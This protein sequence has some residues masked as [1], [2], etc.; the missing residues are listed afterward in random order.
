V[1]VSLLRREVSTAKP[2]DPRQ[3]LFPGSLA[4]YE[5]MTRHRVWQWGRGSS[6]T[7]TAQYFLLEM[8]LGTPDVACI[9][10]V[11]TAV[12]A[13]AVA[14]P[15]FVRWNREYKLGG[16]V[17]GSDLTITFPNGSRVFVTGADRMDLFDR[18]KGIKRIL[19]VVL[20]EAQD[21]LTSVLDYAVTKVFAP[22]LGDLEAKYGLKGRIIIEGTGT[23]KRGYFYRAATDDPALGPSLEFGNAHKLTQWHNPHIADP[24]GEFVAACKLGGVH[25]RKLETPVV[26]PGARPRHYDTD[27]ELTR[28]EW[29]GENNDGAS[30]LQIFKVPQT[31]LVK[32]AMVPTKDLEV[33]CS[34]DLGTVDACAVVTYVWTLHDPNIYLVE[35]VQQ[36]GLAGD[37]QVR[38]A[39]EVAKRQARTYGL[40]L[41]DVTIVGDGAGQGKALLM[42]AKK[43][44][45]FEDLESAEK[46]DKVPNVRLMAG[47]LKAETGTLKICDDEKE[48]LDELKSPEWHPDFV[49][50]RIRGHV[51]DRVDAAYQGFRRA[52]ELHVYEPAPPEKTKLQLVEEKIQ[53]GLKAARTRKA[54][55][56]SGA[57][58]VTTKV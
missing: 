30:D 1:D 45:G 38:F 34:V 19:A 54:M 20:S 4:A 33:L 53:A 48:F 6:K 57:A 55:R 8:A 58:T 40:D 44:Q 35:T 27:D 13:K 17:N 22:R 41:D 7:T 12:R 10:M 14:W 49:G 39:Q 25:Y 11:N 43:A 29:F 15:D 16:K 3:Y 42:M 47:V 37:D 50:E 28:R 56:S 51:P 5:D 2:F 52:R 24:D 23:K 18:K 26:L 9:F 32:R 31:S 46:R 36:Y 21:W